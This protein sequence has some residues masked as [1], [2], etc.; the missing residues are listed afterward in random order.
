MKTLKHGTYLMPA[1]IIYWQCCILV[2]VVFYLRK[3]KIYILGQMPK[4]LRDV[5]MS[6][7]TGLRERFI[8]RCAC[9][10]VDIN[11]WV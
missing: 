6:M 9:E 8:N 10:R 4:K 11:W 5:K 3:V 7:P 2:E 1:S